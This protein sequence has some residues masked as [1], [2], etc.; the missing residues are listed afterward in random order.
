LFAGVYCGSKTTEDSVR[1]LV[2]DS[3]VF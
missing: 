3:I 2:D 1:Q